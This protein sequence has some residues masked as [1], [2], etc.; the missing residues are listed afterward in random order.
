MKSFM[1]LGS[2]CCYV[3]GNR[4]TLKIENL[5]KEAIKTFSTTSERPFKYV[6]LD[7]FSKKIKFTFLKG[8]Y[9]T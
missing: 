4:V 3:F 8:F 6:I 7:I 1:T 5:H 2:D 9:E